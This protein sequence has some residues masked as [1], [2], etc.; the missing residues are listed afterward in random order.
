MP[1]CGGPYPGGA[2]FG[3]APPAGAAFG[4]APPAPNGGFGGIQA[5]Q[6]PGAELKQMLDNTFGKA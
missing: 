4:T 1:A 6:E 2:A 3:G 5:G